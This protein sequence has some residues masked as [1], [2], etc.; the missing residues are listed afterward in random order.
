[1]PQSGWVPGRSTGGSVA[2]GLNVHQGGAHP[3]H[4]L[5]KPKHHRDPTMG[6]KPAQRQVGVRRKPERPV[7]LRHC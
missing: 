5:A 1:M 3:P 6:Q 4:R 2:R 7:V